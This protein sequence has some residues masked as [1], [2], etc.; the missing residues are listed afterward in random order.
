MSSKRHEGRTAERALRAW[1]LLAYSAVGVAL[2]ALAL[3][4]WALF[5]PLAPPPA[6]PRSGILRSGSET[7]PALILSPARFADLPGWRSDDQA[8]AL[9]AFLA[10]C[11][12]LERGGHGSPQPPDL[13]LAIR[14][15]PVVCRQARN[16]DGRDLQSIRRFF[17][18]AL[19]PW[20][21][22]AGSETQG[23]FTGYYEPTLDGSHRRTDVYRYPLYVV[24]PDLVHVDLG[25]FRD[26]WKGHQISGRLKGRNL[27]PYYD[28]AAIENGAL[29]GRG[30][31]LVFVDDPIDLFFLQVQ[32]S[33]KI[34]LNGGKILRV[35]YAGENGLPYTSVGKELIAEGDLLP[36]MVSL[37]TLRGWFLSNPLR[38]R[39]ILDRNRSYVFF[40]ELRSKAPLGSAG[41]PLTPRRSLAVD[42][43]YLPMG[44]PLWLA[45]T[46]PDPEPGLPDHPFERLMVAQ[47][48][49]GAIRG[50]IRGDV[51]WGGGSVAEAIAGR[52]KNQGKIWL[53][54]PRQGSVPAQ[55]LATPPSTPATRRGS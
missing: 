3:A 12:D 22:T 23:L 31:E 19:R 11:R 40:R 34:V 50:P 42:R 4:A 51:Y 2:A 53:L 41:V 36:D 46:I 8:A 44:L 1:K 45:T 17:E 30:L 38:A 18:T 7:K 29:A 24:P 39:F 49:G 48:T 26:E 52:M 6:P 10:T 5:H 27:V 15:W 21:V 20:A 28:R 13:L 16:L 14:G 37:A 33:G 47:D 55:L 43:S 9:S 35:G 32:G 54:L 25:R